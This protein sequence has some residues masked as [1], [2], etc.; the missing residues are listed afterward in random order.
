MGG[1]VYTMKFVWTY[2]WSQIDSSELPETPELTEMMEN[3]TKVT[4]YLTK[5]K[6]T[7]INKLWLGIISRHKQSE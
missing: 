1:K 6:E 3:L 7:F 5:L 4:K 2:I